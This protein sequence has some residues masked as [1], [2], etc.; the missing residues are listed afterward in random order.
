M[1]RVVC[2]VCDVAKQSTDLAAEE[3]GCQFAWC[4]GCGQRT[5]NREVASDTAVIA[6]GSA[7]RFRDQREI[8]EKDRRP[9]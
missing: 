1:T 7:L 2:I 8:F 6:P 3:S 4:D 5:R 9:S